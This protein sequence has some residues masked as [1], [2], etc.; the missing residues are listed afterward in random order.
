MDVKPKPK[1]TIYIDNTNAIALSM[2]H[3]GSETWPITM[4]NTRRLQAEHHRWL[5]RILCISWH[6]MNKTMRVD[7]IK[8]Q[9]EHYQKE[10]L[11]ICMKLNVSIFLYANFLNVLLNSLNDVRIIIHQEQVH[12]R[13]LPRKTPLGSYI[14]I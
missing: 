5:R 13:A 11:Y 4:A 6:N 9:R 8:G 1:T 12:L 2:L 7:G 10:K 14:Y 3:H